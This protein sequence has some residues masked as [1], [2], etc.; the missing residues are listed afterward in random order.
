MIYQGLCK[1]QSGD[2]QLSKVKNHQ[3]TLSVI[4]DKHEN[5]YAH[6]TLSKIRHIQ[7]KPTY[8]LLSLEN[9]GVKFMS[10]EKRLKTQNFQCWLNDHLQEN[11]FDCKKKKML[12]STHKQLDEKLRRTTSLR[13]GALHR[14]SPAHNQKSLLEASIIHKRTRRNTD[15]KSTGTFSDIVFNPIKFTLSISSKHKISECDEHKRGRL[16]RAS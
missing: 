16:Y 1:P 3:S 10:E 6:Y 12:T 7:Q 15:W 5:G 2:F 14:L 8:S 9:R 11:G 4:Y 13:S